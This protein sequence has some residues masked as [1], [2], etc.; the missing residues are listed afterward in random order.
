MSKDNKDLGTV[1]GKLE[2]IIS[3]LQ[4]IEDKLEST[5]KRVRSLENFKSYSL[6][7]VAALVAIGELIARS[8]K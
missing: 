1:I 8:I 7:L 3:Q 4:S 2:R 6:G 5:D